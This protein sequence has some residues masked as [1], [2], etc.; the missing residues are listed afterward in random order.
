MS[1]ALYNHIVKYF[2]LLL[3][4]L[5]LAFAPFSP[6][7]QYQKAEAGGGLCAGPCADKAGQIVQ[8]GLTAAGNVSASI[9]AWAT[10]LL[11]IKEFALDGFAWAAINIIIQEMIRSVTAWVNAGFPSGGPAFVRDLKGFLLN[12]ADGI[13]GD[14][15]LNNTN[16]GFMCSP[17]RLDIQFALAGQYL[18]NRDGG[19]G[20]QP[21]CRV[22][23][24]LQNIRNFTVNVN[25]QVDLDAAYDSTTFAAGGWAWWMAATENQENN[26]FGAYAKAQTALNVALRNAKGEEVKLLDFGQGFLSRKECNPPGSKNCQI[27]TPGQVIE[28]QL[29]EVLNLP[30]GRLQV[31]DEINELVGALLSQL[32]SKVLGS[33]GLFNTSFQPFQDP[34]TGTTYNSF[35]DAMANDT[36]F[37]GYSYGGGSVGGAAIGEAQGY[38]ALQDQ[39]IQTVDNEEAYLNYALSTYPGQISITTLPASLTTARANARAE[40]DR[41]TSII[42]QI[43]I[44]QNSTNSN[45]TPAQQQ[46]VASQITALAAQLPT[47]SDTAQASQA[48]QTTLQSV[49]TS[50]RTTIDADIQAAGGTP[51]GNV[52]PPVA[53]APTVA[54]T[55][56]LI[57]SPNPISLNST[58]TVVWS[59]SG[60]NS[61][62]ATG[63][64]LPSVWGGSVS[65]TGGSIVYGPVTGAQTILNLSCDNSTG[66]TTQSVTI[67]AS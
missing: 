7:F 20:Y 28:T 30:A 47:A 58:T 10:N 60:A 24:I 25:G 27:V 65:S 32:V 51:P 34:N 39:I 38:I 44:L 37:V 67:F 57:A 45:S 63:G 9:T 21:Q 5:G 49:I 26:V 54:P 2:L 19:L 36:A 48:A 3:I 33:I 62:N 56:S 22:S 14:F 16:L 43:Q 15:I 41:V 46:S 17:F 35:L 66:V 50:F 11:Q 23:S 52:P 55:V 6:T 4:V 31:A 1:T 13:A 29:N 64:N 18:A 61:C 42:N 59:V 40:R 12:I 8:A 53:P